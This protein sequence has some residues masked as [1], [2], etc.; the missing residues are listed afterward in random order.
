[1]EGRREKEKRDREVTTY[2]SE[3]SLKILD[4]KSDEL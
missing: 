4:R 1:M 2:Y 3:R